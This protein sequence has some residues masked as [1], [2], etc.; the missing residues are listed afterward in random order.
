MFNI[1]YMNFQ[2]AYEIKA[3]ISDTIAVG[4]SIESLNGKN[5][6]AE[7]QAKMGINFL[8]MFSVDVGGDVKSGSTDSQ[9]VLDTFKVVMT[10]S[11]V[12]NEVMNQCKVINS[13]KELPSNGDLIKLNNIALAVINE[14]EIRTIK[15]LS[16]GLLK[17]F[18]L[19]DNG[20]MD[21]HSVLS[22]M[23][24]DCSYKLCGRKDDSEESVLIK[25]PFS[26]E[27]EFES[28]YNIE[29]LC[30]SEVSI[31]GIYRGKIKLDQ[32]SNTLEYFQNQSIHDRNNDSEIHF[33][34]EVSVGNCY[35][36]DNYVDYHYI[37]LIAIVQDL[38]V[39]DSCSDQDTKKVGKR[40]KR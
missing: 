26:S 23:L 4:K 12:L 10:K 20:D 6:S 30:I 3:M 29:D 39:N 17:G 19:P 25:I 14:S 32:L 22:S 1:Y 31:V 18:K 11:L 15:L 27:N 40:S 9:K 7:A 8:K 34:Q 21:I 5:I 16:N 35:G 36:D 24:K 28:L 33:S 2:K 13:I 37:D 38:K